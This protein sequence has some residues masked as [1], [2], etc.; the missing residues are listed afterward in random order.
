MIK[1]EIKITQEIRNKRNWYANRFRELPE[2]KHMKV[3]RASKLK[4]WQDYNLKK[5]VAIDSLLPML[6]Q[7]FEERDILCQIVNALNSKEVKE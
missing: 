5:W 6:E 2:G 3:L 7:A 4:D 1:L